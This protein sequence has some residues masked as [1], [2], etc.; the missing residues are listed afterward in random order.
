MKTH[1]TDYLG[2]PL[3]ILLVVF[4][5]ILAFKPTPEQKPITF[6][7]VGIIN[8]T[9]ATTLV[10]IHYECIKY[11]NDHSSYISTCWQQCEKLGK[12]VC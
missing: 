8:S 11:C 7:V 3:A 2:I 1:I 12:E 5:G 4:L 10:S 9:N 6:E